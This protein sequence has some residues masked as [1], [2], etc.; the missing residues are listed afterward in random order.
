MD[1][2]FINDLVVKCIIGVNPEEREKSQ[3]VIINLV[4]SVDLRQAEK[5][6]HLADTV[7]YSSL[8]KKVISLVEGARRFTV[9]ALAADIAALCLEEE[10]VK[11]VRVR[12]EKPAAL[13]SARSAGVEIEREKGN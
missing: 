7:S 4:L 6:D 2:I 1:Q 3:E 11:R 5:T 13:P 9:E 12:L 8:A 10:G